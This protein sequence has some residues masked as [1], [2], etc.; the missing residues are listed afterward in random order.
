[1]LLFP[2]ATTNTRPVWVA[3][4]MALFSSLFLYAPNDKL[5]T[6]IRPER[7]LW[8]T[9]N[10]IATRIVLNEPVPFE[11]NALTSII[12]TPL[13]TPYVWEP[14]KPATCVPWPLLSPGPS[15]VKSLPVLALPWNSGWP[16]A[17]PES[18]T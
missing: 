13:A 14:I 15:S 6:P 11:F 17:I 3:W 9:A 2:A 18:I 12:C 7:N 1:M 10:S 16:I 5:A 8:F 4:S